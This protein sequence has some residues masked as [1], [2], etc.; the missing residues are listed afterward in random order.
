M[1][2]LIARHLKASVIAGVACVAVAASAAASTGPATPSQVAADVAS[3][4]SITTLPSNLAP[5]LGSAQNDTAYVGTPT[6][7]AC[8]TPGTTLKT[9]RCVFGDKK[10][11]KTMVLWGDSHAFM[12]FPAV[13]AV[14]KSA[15]WKLVA[16]LKYGCPVASVSVWDGVSK[17][18]YKVCDTFR[19]NMIAAIN[20]LNPSLVI[21]TEAFT[22]LA[23]SGGGAYNTITTAQ[24][25]TGLTK[26]LKALHSTR[27]KKLIIG[28]TIASGAKGL[29]YPPQCLIVNTATVQKCT[30]QDTPVQQAQ[31]ASEVAA[32]K[33]TSTTYVD[34]LPWLCTTP[35][36][37]SC[38]SVIGDSVNGYKV[39]YYST[40][41]ITETYALFLA[42]VLGNALKP[43]MH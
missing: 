8:N 12:W 37:G 27:M 40:G 25:Q 17:V 34:A 18:P 24:W 38:S 7:A 6:L 10:G 22:S 15:H 9:S 28:N 19:A 14:A 3:S 2:L 5:A 11:T 4:V 36:P 33:A 30:I 39:V 31:R 35:S 32:A 41:H 26:T 20:R 43:H 23:A 16:L 13:N 42:T 29:A 1:R 21:V